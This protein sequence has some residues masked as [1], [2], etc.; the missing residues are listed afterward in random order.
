MACDTIQPATDSVG[1]RVWYPA[2]L[3][4]AGLPVPLLGHGS[5][6]MLELYFAVLITL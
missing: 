2:W 6:G 4:L 1:I 3:F 5:N